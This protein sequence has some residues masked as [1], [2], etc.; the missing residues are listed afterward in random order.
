VPSW[1][2][3][4]G[5]D[6]GGQPELDTSTWFDSKIPPAADQPEAANLRASDTDPETIAAHEGLA[7]NGAG[8]PSVPPIPPLSKAI[9][10]AQATPDENA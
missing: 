10:E 7:G 3:Q 1:L 8:V 4:T 9:E 6:G 2:N 5:T